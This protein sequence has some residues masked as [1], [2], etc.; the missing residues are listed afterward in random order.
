MKVNL[1]AYDLKPSISN[2]KPETINLN[3][4]KHYAFEPNKPICLCASLHTC[5][6]LKWSQKGK[7]I[8]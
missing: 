3:A 7:R 6:W 8:T 4:L 2:L 5:D 1:S